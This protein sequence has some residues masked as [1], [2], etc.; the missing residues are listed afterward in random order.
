SVLSF[1]VRFSYWP[2]SQ[3]I[4]VVFV[5]FAILSVFS[6][7]LK[8]EHRW[9]ALSLLMILGAIYTH[10]L[11]AVV[12]VASICGAVVLGYLHPST[13]NTPAVMRLMR[14]TIGLV[15]LFTVVQLFFVTNFGQKAILRIVA[16]SSSPTIPDPTAAI[17]PVMLR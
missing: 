2:I 5:L 9:L 17:D 14:G 3:T 8:G 10:K 6:Y 13:R 1:S 15:T 7:A 11:A 4:G 16:Q 12:I